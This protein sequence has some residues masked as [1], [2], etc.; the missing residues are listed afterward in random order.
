MYTYKL[1]LIH[2]L[3]LYHLFGYSY[4]VRISCS[5]MNAKGDLISY[6]AKTIFILSLYAVGDFRGKSW[7]SVDTLMIL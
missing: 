5:L 3:A 7:I 4:T 1:S 2:K 6:H